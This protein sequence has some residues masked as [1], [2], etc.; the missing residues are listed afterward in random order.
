MSAKLAERAIE[1][2]ALL[3]HLFAQTALGNGQPF[4]DA[5]AED[6]AWTVTGSTGRSETHQGKESLR[7]VFIPPLRRALQSIERTHALRLI[8]ARNVVCVVGRGENSYCWIV[9]FRAR[10]IVALKVFLDRERLCS[11][12]GVLN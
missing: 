6:V 7:R 12:P 3:E 9:E 10:R 2:K 5:I 11:V 8:A 1:N 4:L